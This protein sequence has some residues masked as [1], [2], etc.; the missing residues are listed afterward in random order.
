M[1]HSINNRSQR[2][3]IARALQ[4]CAGCA[5]LTPVVGLVLPVGHET[6]EIDADAELEAVAADVWEAA[7]AGAVLFYVEYMTEG[8]QN[9]LSQLS[10]HY[11]FDSSDSAERAY[12]MNHCSFC[13]M[14]QDDF[15]LY[16]EPEGA[17][18]PV[19]AETAAKIRLHD[20]AEPFEAQASG[21]ACAPDFFD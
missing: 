17:S 14:K 15:D 5:Q 16:C 4:R 10:Q 21:Y 2:Y 19:S 13:G 9:R 18:M 6:L 8:V 3:S 11:R 7:E 20:V 12:W 1:P